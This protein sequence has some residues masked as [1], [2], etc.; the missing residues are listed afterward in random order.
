ML[1][2]G[3]GEERKGCE[4]SAPLT[5]SSECLSHIGQAEAICCAVPAPWMNRGLH[6]AYVSAALLFSLLQLAKPFLK[7]CRNIYLSI[8]QATAFFSPFFLLFF[9]KL[10]FFSVFLCMLSFQFILQTPRPSLRVPWAIFNL[11]AGSNE[12]SPC[13]SPPA[14]VRRGLAVWSRERSQATRGHVLF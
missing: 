12:A 2:T 11:C 7:H 4:E 10:F 5:L 1:G 3:R 6:F 14:G 13:P 9:W 8:P